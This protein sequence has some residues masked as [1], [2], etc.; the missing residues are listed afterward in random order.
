MS[1]N[2]EIIEK[3][4]KFEKDIIIIN[5][6]I[7]KIGS[8]KIDVVDPRANKIKQRPIWNLESY[9]QLAIHRVYD[10][11]IETT[12]AWNNK[13]P[14]VAFLLTRAIYENTAY[15]YDLFHK[16]KAYYEED[17]FNEIHEIIVNRLV[18]S[19]LSSNH[20][21]IINV[22]TAINTVAKELPD[23]KEFYEFISDFCHPNYSGMHG[24]Y[25]KLDK[26]HVRFYIN[27]EY[28]YTEET[29]SFIITGL[30]TGLELFYINAKNLL[31]N[32]NELN[33]FFYKHQT[34]VKDKNAT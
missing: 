33:D 15:I 14:A 7:D 4:K 31:D 2:K 17:N 19:R 3:F 22:L 6:L 12:N 18:G 26:E 24:I 23:F 16:I 25:G 29:F 28:G 32:I 20:R 9:I 5:G 30:A 21:K 10:L 11:G 27:K 13:N 8:L 1:F 34:L